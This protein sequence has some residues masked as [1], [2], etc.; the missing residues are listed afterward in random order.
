MVM[1][2][3]KA[4]HAFLKPLYLVCDFANSRGASWLCLTK[5]GAGE[6]TVA[7]LATYHKCVY[8]GP[9]TVCAQIWSHTHIF[10]AHTHAVH[11]YGNA[12]THRCMHT[13]FTVHTGH[14]SRTLWST[15][16]QSIH[17]VKW[18]CHTP[19]G[20]ILPLAIFDFTTMLYI[21][22]ACL[23]RGFLSSKC[24]MIFQN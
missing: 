1:L 12:W 15:N 6:A 14:K 9:C 11:T 17:S 22:K 23:P 18:S 2:H 3:S 8:V 19:Y 20:D 16:I 7:K 13:T 21:S 24:Y 5:P 4:S 10:L